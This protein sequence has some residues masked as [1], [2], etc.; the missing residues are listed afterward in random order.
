MVQT[1]IFVAC[2]APSHVLL[3]L[4][5]PKA[6]VTGVLRL[7]TP[8]RIEA[9]VTVFAHLADKL[10]SRSEFGAKRFFFQLMVWEPALT[11]ASKE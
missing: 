5:T 4:A 7:D 2:K 8:E 11:T 9:V 3:S 10:E 1:C 6:T